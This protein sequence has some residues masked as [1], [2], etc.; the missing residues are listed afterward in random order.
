MIRTESSR[1]VYAN[2]W[3][4]LREDAIRYP[5]GT[6]GTYSVVDKA[7]AVLVIAYEDDGFTLIEQF[8]YP[9]GGPSVE[10]PQGTWPDGRDAPQEELARTELAE[11][12]GLRAR[13]LEHIGHFKYAPGL[14]S[15]GCDVFLATGLTR[16]D[17]ALEHTEQG[18]RRLWVARADFEARMARGA[19]LDGGTL[20]G[21]ALFQR[22]L[23]T[24]PRDIR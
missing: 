15:Q 9:I 17:Q 24:H 18:L 14:T 13:H 6:A 23:S 10:F 12:T 5:D 19:I 7:D 3:V 16:G 1:T 8:R 22:Y 20:A 2:R 4:S 11:E 21:Y